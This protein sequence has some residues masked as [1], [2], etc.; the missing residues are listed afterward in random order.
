MN[1]VHISATCL[2]VVHGG[3]ETKIDDDEY[4]FACLRRRLEP[5][6]PTSNVARFRK[7]LAP[8]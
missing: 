7:R 2:L 8:I 6:D 4:D 5:L 3:V 1:I